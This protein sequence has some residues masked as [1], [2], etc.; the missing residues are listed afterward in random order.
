MESVLSESSHR[1][2]LLGAGSVASGRLG[3]G[4]IIG[5]SKSLQVDI[6]LSNHCVKISHTLLQT[7]PVQR[8]CT[9]V[10]F[11]WHP[12]QSLWVGRPKDGPLLVAMHLIFSLPDVFFN[13]LDFAN[14]QVPDVDDPFRGHHQFWDYNPTLASMAVTCKAF[15]EPTL[16]VL[17]RSQ[18]S[19][20]PLVR[21][22]PAELWE[23]EV[24]GTY[25]NK[26]AYEIVS[27]T[28]FRS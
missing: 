17:W 22:L 15:T 19:L 16:N 11:V 24:V 25:F 21:T 7:F 20:G 2:N 23:E 13:I 12:H 1:T 27:R 6:G 18:R 4:R 14:L 9:V 8:F 3:H 5:A 26:P 10:F 28:L